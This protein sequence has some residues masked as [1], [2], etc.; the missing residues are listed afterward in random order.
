MELDL[1]VTF[2]TV[3]NLSDRAIGL[4]I[5]SKNLGHCQERRAYSGSTQGKEIG[6]VI[7]NSIVI[8]GILLTSFYSEPIF[9]PLNAINTPRNL[10]RPVGLFLIINKSAQLD[11]SFKGLYINIKPAYIGIG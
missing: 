7:L 2:S 9:N 4:N 11:Y 5:E 10:N 8:L 3:L 1:S 6:M